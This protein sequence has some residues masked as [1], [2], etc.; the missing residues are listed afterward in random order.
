MKKFVKGVFLGAIVPLGM[1]GFFYTVYQAS[2]KKYEELEEKEIEKQKE[3][4]ECLDSL[5]KL[6]EDIE[7]HD[8]DFEESEE[9]NY[10]L[11]DEEF[12][13]MIDGFLEDVKNNR[14]DFSKIEK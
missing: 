5:E 14:I 12:R 4:D 8:S 1:C 7:E 3:W 6:M 10:T 11:S 2:K 9:R 13:K